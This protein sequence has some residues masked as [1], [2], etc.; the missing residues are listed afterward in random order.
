MSD[1]DLAAS[2]AALVTRVRALEDERDIMAT[3]YDY[4]IAIDYGDEATFVDSWTADAVLQW[5]WRPAFEGR[6][7]ILAAFRAHT[8]APDKFHKHVVVGPRIA[9]DGDQA[10]VVSYFARLDADDGQRPVMRSFGR[11]LDELVRC[12]DGKWRIARR[13]A[14][15]EAALASPGGPG[16]RAVFAADPEAWS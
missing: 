1:A 12:A 5:P 10:A 4:G 15:A 7:A 13:E 16:W 6:D 3:L 11:Y 2:V 8:H 9:L 14:E